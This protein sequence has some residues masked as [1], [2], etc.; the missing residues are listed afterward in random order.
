MIK[1]TG[2]DDQPAAICTLSSIGKISRDENKKSS[3]LIQK[4]IEA[5]LGISTSRQYLVFED[6]K[7]ENVGYQAIT[8]DD[9]I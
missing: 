8:F 4:A 3:A 2:A 7:K 9:L 1:N 5:K 6:L